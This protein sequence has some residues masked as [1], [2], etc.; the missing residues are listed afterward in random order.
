MNPEL[1]G[2]C[3]IKAGAARCIIWGWLA[4]DVWFTLSRG[5]KVCLPLFGVYLIASH[6]KRYVH[7]VCKFGEYYIQVLKIYFE[8]KYVLRWVRRQISCHQGSQCTYYK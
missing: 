5:S 1:G 3:I 7:R 6:A 8:V 2:R 4:T